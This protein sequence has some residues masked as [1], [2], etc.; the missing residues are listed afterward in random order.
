VAHAID[1][2]G[3][4]AFVIGAGT[5]ALNTPWTG[6]FISGVQSIAKFRKAIDS[7]LGAHP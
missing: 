2:G 6:V 5:P 4:P 7:A 3:T 1:A